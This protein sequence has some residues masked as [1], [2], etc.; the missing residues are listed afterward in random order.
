MTQSRDAVYEEVDPGGRALRVDGLANCP[1]TLKD[2]A[3][4]TEL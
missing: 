4:L 1:V 2:Y 3:G